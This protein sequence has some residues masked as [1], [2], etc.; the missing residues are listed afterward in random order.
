MIG[1]ER[2]EGGTGRGPRNRL[3]FLTVRA[4]FIIF[5]GILIVSSVGFGSF[6]NGGPIPPIPIG[7]NVL[8]V[9]GNTFEFLGVV[10]NIDGTSTWSYRATSGKRPTLSYWVIELDSAI[11]E[12]RI[13]KCSESYDVG[14]DPATGIYGLKFDTP[15]EKRE[16]REIVFVLD[17]WYI[18][19]KTRIA[20]KG[21]E[22]VEIGEPFIGPVCTGGGNAAPIANDDEA[23]THAGKYVKIAVLA[24]DEDPDG[25]PLKITAT[26]QPRNGEAKISG[27]KIKYTPDK[28]FSGIDLFEYTISDGNGGTASATVT[29][30]VERVN[31]PPHAG[32]DETET[33]ENRAVEIDIL[34]NDVDSDG[35]IDP[36][37][38]AIVREPRHG[39]VM[40]DPETGLATYI[41]DPDQC[42]NDYFQYTVADNEGAVSNRAKVTIKVACNEPP[43]AV[44]DRATAEA[45]SSVNIDVLANDS[46]SD[47]EINRASVMIVKDPEAGMVNV[48]PTSGIVTY[49]PSPDSGRDDSF[50]YTV[51]DDGGAVS[52]RGLVTITIIYNEPPRAHD[53]KAS[54][55]ENA[56]VGINVLANDEDLDGRLDPTSVT[57]ARPPREGTASVHPRT[58][59]ITYTPAPRTCGEDNFVYTV[60]DDDG[61]VSNEAEVEVFVI[62]A[63]PPVASDDLYNAPEG[64]TIEIDSPGVLANDRHAPM[65]D[66]RAILV[67]GVEHGR[68]SLDP[69]GSFV[70]VHDG[71]ETQE[72]VFTYKANDGRND[73]NVATVRI[74][75]TPTND[76]PVA[77]DDRVDTEE[78]TSVRID[79]LANDTDP[80]GDRLSVDSVSDPDNGI[81][82]STGHEIIYTPDPD[83]NGID[84]FTYTVTDGNG[85][86]ATAQVTVS[87]ASVNDPPIAQ[88]DAGATDEDTPVVIQ[89]LGNDS[90]PD[91]DH[92]TIQSVTQPS[93]GS[94]ESDGETVTYTPNA[95]FNGT[96]RFTYTV[97]DEN[98][99]TATAQVTVSVAVVNDR[100]IAQDDTGATDEDTLVTI[101]VLENDSD[102]DGDPLA[103]RSMTQPLNGS[104]ESDG[105]AVTYTPDA[106]FNGTDSFTY[107]VSDGN[108]GTATAQVTVSVASVND[109]PIAQD[110][111]GAT[112]EDTPVTIAVLENDSDPDGNSLTI[113]SVTQPSNGSAESDGETVTYTPN[114]GFNGIDSFV[115]TI[116]DGNGGTATAQVTVAVAMV[117]EEPAAQDDAVATG[118][119]V[120]VTIAVLE[121][122]SDPDGDPLLIG[123]LTQPLHGRAVLSGDAIIYTPERNFNGTDSFTYTVTDGNGGRD[124]ATVV[125]TVAAINDPPVGRDDSTGTVEDVSITI[126]VLVN[127]SDVDGDTLTIGAVTQPVAGSLVN[128]GSDLTYTPEPEFNGIDRFTY[129]VSDGNGG[130]AS[131]TVTVTVA[132]RNDPPIAQDDSA[133]T[134]EGT[135]VTIPI[136]EN[137]SDP[138]RDFLLVESISQ[139]EHGSVLNGKTAISYIPDD[140]FSGIDSFTYVVSDGNGGTARAAVTVSVAAVNDRPIAQGDGAVTDEGR[141]VAIPVLSNDSDPDGDRL[142][143]ES[144]EDPEH[145]VAS[146]NGTDVIYTP[147]PGFS[148]VET[149]SY[150]VSDG[151][152]GTSTADVVVAVAAV[153]EPPTAQD[154]SATTGAGSSLTIDPL[155]NDSDPDGD[156]LTI[157][158]FTQPANGTV[159]NDRGVFVYTPASGFSGTDTFTY[160]VSDGN[161]GTDA[162]TVTIGV[163][164]MIGGGGAATATSCEGRVI[165]NEIAWAGTAADPRDEWI[166]LRNLGTTP[167]DLTGWTIRWRRTRPITPDEQEWNVIELAGVISGASVPACEEAANENGAPIHFFKEEPGEIPWLVVS[168]PERE[169]SGYYTIERRDD[170]TVEDVPADAVYDASRT[171]DLDLS[172]RGEVIALFDANGNLVDTANASYL[173]RD[174]WTAGSASTFATMERTDPF[175]PD[176]PDNWHTNT[177]IVTRGRDAKGRPVTG[178]ARAPNSPP[179]ENLAEL[180]GI[181]PATVRAGETVEVDFTLPRAERRETGWPW[182]SVD[183]PGFRDPAGGGGSIDMSVYSF[184]GHYESGDKYVLDIDTSNLAPGRHIFWIVFGQGKALVVPIVVTP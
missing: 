9:G 117:N 11:G 23:K 22:D 78:D 19:G 180:A 175:G 103:I 61:A 171:L 17:S 65:T 100:P 91:G 160:T 101:A 47:G 183:R 80:D 81:A 110:D 164:P 64:G 57:I 92:L 145:G 137:D 56:S 46:D 16:T 135:L 60:A 148:G 68:L 95:D 96:D 143:V 162:A 35:T 49:T 153:N 132:P 113:Q 8:R 142:T 98:G 134:D 144:V 7:G 161:G 69:A 15:Y 59:V 139:P 158:S 58:G 32:A 4:L 151:K 124:T 75:I 119:D 174:G 53:D 38:V 163:T 67:D 48:N 154:D 39:S 130:T 170:K 21:G 82:V 116:S 66:L 90:D 51:E 83:F 136:L 157:V 93:N 26:S 25:D 52:N 12:E 72:D 27:K 77:S 79:V 122:D 107:T 55:D 126:D 41:P 34:S 173:G 63:P 89:V 37:T 42:K 43:V 150:T 1:N 40:L 167:V 114:A 102:P 109:R 13:L 36:T 165:I 141:S 131:A 159:T 94:A 125:I 123:S 87:V 28:G 6:P 166:E 10:Y 177:G 54:T 18:A 138:D 33:L 181:E 71:S 30:E 5:V 129:T 50:E 115:Y 86:T 14:E 99:G 128:N 156:P 112:D 3:S 45:G 88:D 133:K 70:Y 104:V 140:G 121:N 179:L 127:D 73:S 182:V 105:E 31:V 146:T 84:R 118:E 120:P 44:D 62:C 111:T 29:V 152:G 169:A 149:F 168:D 74:A 97:S 85:G 106:D 20:I 2:E 172:D 76:S 178:T 155:G 147:D 176:T 108:G 184:S 24:N